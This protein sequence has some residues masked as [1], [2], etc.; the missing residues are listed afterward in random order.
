VDAHLD[1]IH[2][3]GMLDNASGSAAILEIAQ[4]LANTPTRNRLRFIWFGGEELG[5]L[6]SDHYVN[7]LSPQELAKVK[8]DLDADVL[9]TPNYVVGVIDPGDGVGLFR[10]QPGTPVPPSILGP[11]GVARDHAISYLESIR[12]NHVLFSADGTDAVRFQLAGSPASGLLTGQDCC[13]LASDVALFGGHEGNYEG[14]VPGVDG[15]C[16]DNPFRWCDN[17]A[18][19]DLEVLTFMA[20]TFADMVGQMAWDRQA[21]ASPSGSRGDALPHS[22]QQPVGRLRGA[23]D[24]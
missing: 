3:A 8:Y 1:A 24:S 4:Q 22:T 14:T 11:S 19:N 5:L 21:F 6:G 15:G 9:A 2:G 23:T 13:K 16:V 7:S 12:K 10:R 20:K 18:D 17:L